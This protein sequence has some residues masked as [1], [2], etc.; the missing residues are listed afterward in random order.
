MSGQ[1]TQSFCEVSSKL[2]IYLAECD[3]S[4]SIFGYARSFSLSGLRSARP[5]FS[6]SPLMLRSTLAG[7]LGCEGHGGDTWRNLSAGFRLAILL[8]VLVDSIVDSSHR[9]P[10]LLTRPLHSPSLPS[11]FH[12]S[13]SVLIYAPLTC[14]KSSSIFLLV[15]SPDLL[16]KKL[17]IPSKVGLE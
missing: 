6:G 8:R 16:V 3:A 15:R 9:S 7:V 1:T 12:L 4:C 13:A 5:Y 2:T 11:S 10:L 14:L 17:R